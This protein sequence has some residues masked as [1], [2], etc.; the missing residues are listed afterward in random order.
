MSSHQRN[1]FPVMV[2]IHSGGF[3]TVHND[4]T[5]LVENGNVIV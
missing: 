5:P 2:W 4:P 1:G 3:V